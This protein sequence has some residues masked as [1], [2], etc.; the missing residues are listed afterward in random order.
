MDTKQRL[1][2]VLYAINE[3]SN[4]ASLGFEEKL[5]RVIAGITEGLKARSG[6][7]MLRK[8]RKFLEVVASTNPEIVGI[9]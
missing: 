2:G 1:T 4:D 7:I 9:R 3:V 6:S 8:G 5:E